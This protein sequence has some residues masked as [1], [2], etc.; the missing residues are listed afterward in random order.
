MYCCVVEALLV[1]YLHAYCEGRRCG[2]VIVTSMGICLG[3][4]NMSQEP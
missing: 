3:F 4:A 1:L 2:A